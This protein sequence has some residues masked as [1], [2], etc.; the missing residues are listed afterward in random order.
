MTK[1]QLKQKISSLRIEC[2]NIE[3][4]K[5]SSAEDIYDAYEVLKIMENMLEKI[6]G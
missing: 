4:C 6:D 2:Y 3:N 5:R 1:K